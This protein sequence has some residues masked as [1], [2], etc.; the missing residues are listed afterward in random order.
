MKLELNFRLINYNI[1][2][3]VIG[4]NK[5]EEIAKEAYQTGVPL[6]EMIIKKKILP[7]EEVEK[8]L[9]PTTMIGKS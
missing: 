3:P 8:L 1:L 9:D 2:A 5:A 6:K 7:A 4:Y